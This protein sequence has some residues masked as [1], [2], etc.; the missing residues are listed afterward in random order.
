[1]LSPALL[2]AAALCAAPTTKIALL[3]IPPSEGLPEP[4]AAAISEAA[5]AEVRRVPDVQL[6]TQQE[7][8][9][10]L[11]FERQ[12]QLL[13]CGAE[14]CMAQI[15][16]ALGV[17]RI[18]TGTLYKLPESWFFTLKIMDVKKAKT[19]GDTNRRLR[20]AS[21]DDVVDQ[22]PAMVAELFGAKPVPGPVVAPQPEPAKQ[23]P[24]K[25][26]PAKTEPVVQ[27][28]PTTGVIKQ[29]PNVTEEP[30]S[31]APKLD[32]LRVA[33]NGKGR[34]L[35]YPKGWDTDRVFVGDGKSFHQARII[36]GGANGAERTF[37]YRAW[38]PRFGNRVDLDYKE[39]KLTL[40][41]GES[42][43]D[44]E[45][46][47][48]PEAEGQK[49][50]KKAR[51]L[52]PRWQR[53]PWGLARDDAGNYFF[54]DKAREPEGNSDYRFYAGTKGKMQGYEVTDHIE[55]SAA[56]IW[57]TPAGRLK[58]PLNSKNEAEWI[59]GSQRTAL[60]WVAIDNDIP[61]MI[62]TALGPYS[63][64]RLGTPCDLVMP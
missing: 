11:G 10:L 63:G 55:D 7:I 15:G 20:K 57:I 64:E 37:S 2:M 33:T 58:H 50:L 1:M 53:Y 45:L 13:S 3:P 61:K 46:K 51:F 56:Q 47:V 4:M 35:A 27:A 19:I 29:G 39:R 21:L 18:I 42:H 54:V 62:Y 30:L 17:D 14:D 40:T 23:D 6:V 59:V 5:A 24:A 36:G 44:V 26:E 60:S 16:G 38:D 9:T 12:K 48:L 22:L 25:A 49:L 43:K 31:P 32:D 34:Y 28:L 41:C 52:K 8:S